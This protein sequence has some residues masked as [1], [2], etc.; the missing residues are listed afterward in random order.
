VGT[1]G[2]LFG[3]LYTAGLFLWLC[4]S[5]FVALGRAVVVVGDL[6]IDHG[7]VVRGVLTRAPGFGPGL[8]PPGDADAQPA[9]PQYF[10]GPA[11]FD[12]RRTAALCRRRGRELVDGAL[13]ATSE[14]WFTESESSGSPLIRRPCGA[15]LYA[16]VLLGAALDLPA[17]ALLLALYATGL[18]VAIAAVHATATALRLLD[19]AVLWAK[20]LHRGMICPHCYEHV[21]YPWYRCPEPTCR[22]PHTDIRQARYGVWRRRCRCGARL[23]ALLLTGAYRLAANCPYC[24]KPMSD[25]TGLAREV[26]LPMVGGTSAGKTHLMAAML[27]ALVEAAERG[28]RAVTLADSDTRRQ[29][30]YLRSALAQ[31]GHVRG[32]SR[33]LPHSHA[34]MLGGG[35]EQRLVHIFD[36]AG[37]HYI[38]R[39]GADALRYAADARTVVFVLDPMA[40][41]A[42]WD[43]LTEADRAALDPA[44]ASPVDPHLVFQ[45]TVRAM[46]GMGA[47]LDRSRLAVAVSKA[48]LTGGHGPAPTTPNGWPDGR[49]VGTPAGTS[50]GPTAVL[51]DGPTDGEEIREWLENRLGLGNLVRSMR[52]EFR[53]TRFFRTAAV[54]G[55]DGLVD[56]SVAA[57]AE[58]CLGPSH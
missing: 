1:D 12:L 9:R 18:C 24:G 10:Y 7:R 48:D 28:G 41:P 52:T 46:L 45:Q 32:T 15:V 37:E 51:R 55:A 57:L 21:E 38:S 58:W 4:V 56:P 47:A 26:V 23:P 34:L 35:R 42:F 49:S 53:E 3:V 14:R 40:V 36:A 17:A 31:R 54:T 29:Y 50:A 25:D 39:E 43:G 20:D 11:Q 33:E 5:P 30:A 6:M 19:R 13:R 8:P 22:E 2:F 44:N 27:M 16:G